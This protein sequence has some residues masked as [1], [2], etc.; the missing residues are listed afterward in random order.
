MAT[1]AQRSV[2]LHMQYA[3]GFLFFCFPNLQTSGRI[4]SS[5]YRQGFMEAIKS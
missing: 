4:L 3:L 5:G 2:W 1:T